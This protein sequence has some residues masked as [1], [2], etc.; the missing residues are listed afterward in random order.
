M[1]RARSIV[2]ISGAVVAALTLAA[3]SSNKSSGGGGSGD[4][5][6]MLNY[7]GSDWKQKIQS[8]AESE[9]ALSVYN[10]NTAIDKAAVAFGKAYPKIKVSKVLAQSSDLLT[11]LKSETAA[12]KVGGDILDT[13]KTSILVAQATGYTQPFYLPATANLTE[14]SYSGPAGDNGQVNWFITQQSFS[15]LGWNTQ[16]VKN[17]P[18]TLEDFLDPQYKGQ[19]S[20]DGHSGG[21]TWIGAVLDQMGTEKGTQFLQGLAKQ[22]MTVQNVTAATMIKFMGS[23]E[24]LLNPDAGMSDT[25]ALK[26]KGQ[27]VDWAPVGPVLE[28]PLT[29]ALIKGA[30]HPCAGLLFADYLLSPE[31]QKIITDNGFISPVKGVAQAS[32]MQGQ[33]LDALA[34]QAWDPTTKYDANSYNENYNN[35]SDL[36]SKQ[37]INK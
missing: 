18:K 32:Y 36:L 25:L 8:C 6:A 16:K 14:K 12:N 19:L 28:L 34:S 24:V 7:H 20:I 4:T 35:W 10:A 22:G 9:G 5:A 31:G 29:F 23:G 33:D 30:P 11:R 17:P 1:N 15:G 3:C 13:Y 2:M 21:I 27:P 26:A 37:F